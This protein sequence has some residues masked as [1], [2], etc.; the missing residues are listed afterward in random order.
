[1]LIALPLLDTWLMI[2]TW[3]LL[4]A[5]DGAAVRMLH[6]RSA[7]GAVPRA[8]VL[9]IAAISLVDALFAATTGMASVVAA[10]LAGFALTR[11]LQ[12]F[13]PGT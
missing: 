3:V 6:R 8:V 10:C 12:R 4:A 2:P 13:V 7:P 5:T 1:V 11:G 9:L